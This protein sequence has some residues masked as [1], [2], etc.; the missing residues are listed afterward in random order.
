MPTALFQYSPIG[1]THILARGF[2][3]WILIDNEV[4]QSPIGTD[5]IF[6]C[7]TLNQNGIKSTNISHANGILGNRNFDL[8][9]GK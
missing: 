3:L 7:Q 5:D 2:N 8:L 6:H 1:T 9:P 4:W